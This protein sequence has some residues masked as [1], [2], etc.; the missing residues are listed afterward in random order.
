MAIRKRNP[1]VRDDHQRWALALCS[2]EAQLSELSNEFWDHY[3]VGSKV[4][5]RLGAVRSSV[6]K[7]RLE[8]DSAVTSE[9]G[10]DRAAWDV[11]FN[12]ETRKLSGW[13]DEIEKK[14]GG[15]R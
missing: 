2:I 8:L 13:I 9:S 10:G 5:S 15:V 4:H 6:Q 11:Y 14:L 1:P 3:R 12:V 7:L